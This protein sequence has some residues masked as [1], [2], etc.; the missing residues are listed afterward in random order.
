MWLS[1]PRATRDHL[2]EVFGLERSGVTEI[3]DQDVVSDGYT[4]DDLRKISLEKM[5]EYIGSE[6]TF[7]RAWEI[8]LAKVHA[9]L[10]PPVAEIRRVDGEP[11]IVDIVEVIEVPTGETVVEEVKVQFTPEEVKPFCDQCASKGVRHLKYCPKYVAIEH[12]P[13]AEA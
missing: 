12:T 9:E 11:T 7:S 10:N 8:T 3:R 4:I 1:L 6:E 2:I 13:H 5:T